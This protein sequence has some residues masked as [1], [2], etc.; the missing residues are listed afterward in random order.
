MR[1]LLAI[2]VAVLASATAQAHFLFVR[3]LPPAEGGRAAEVYYSELAEAGDPRFVAKIA[4]TRLWLQTTPGKLT[5]LKAQE[6]SDRLRAWLPA[7]GS[8]MVVGELTYGVLARPKQTPFLLRHFPKAIAGAPADLNPLPPH[9]KLPLEIA[10][11][12]SD[13]G[14]RLQA[15]RDGKPLPGVEFVTVDAQLKNLTLKADGEGVATWT[16]PAAGGYAVYTRNTRVEAGEH[17]GKKYDEIRDF[18]TLAFQWPLARTTGDP[19]AVKVFEEALAARAAWRDF[20]GFTAD[21]AGNLDGRPFTGSVRISAKGEVLFSDSDPNREESVSPWVQD[22]LAS[23][24]LHRLARPDGKRGPPLVW[25]GED[26]DDHPLGRLLVFEGGQFASSYRVKDRQLMAVNRVLGQENMTI[27]VLE[28]D[29]NTDG[30]FLPRAYTV[31]YWD[32]A[33]GE[34]KRSESIQQR[35][36]RVGSWDLPARHTLTT[37][38]AAGVSVR[39]FMMSKFELLK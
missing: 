18:A 1:M 7:S 37:A 32:G 20:P 36:Q 19:V 9:G 34:L 23:I 26:R 16:P 28:N 6:T 39:T 24:V 14:I 8:V 25:F 29:R 22:Q 31:Q 10:A 12:V 38:S 3:I 30:Q 21:I 2:S 27:T 13:T 5:P 4:P 33:S 15:L 11:T 17:G 35:W